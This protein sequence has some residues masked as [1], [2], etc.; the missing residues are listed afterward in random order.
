[1]WGAV[2][3]AVA[4]VVIGALMGDEEKGGSGGQGR[5][6]QPGFIDY[7]AMLGDIE[8]TSPDP[9][10]GKDHHIAGAPDSP[11]YAQAV[12]NMLDRRRDEAI[13]KVGGP[14][15]LARLLSQDPALINVYQGETNFV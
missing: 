10:P 2:A 12:K 8:R 5:D 3:A 1:M 7:V 14:E 11:G 15:E 4:P 9:I 6:R 13:A